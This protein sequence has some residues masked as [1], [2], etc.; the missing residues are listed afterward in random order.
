M[1]SCRAHGY[2]CKR[3]HTFVH[4]GKDKQS[5]GSLGLCPR[6]LQKIGLALYALSRYK[7]SACDVQIH[8]LG[9]AGR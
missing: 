7:R 1:A 6:C 2:L 5:E 9:L 8:F 4:T 3:G